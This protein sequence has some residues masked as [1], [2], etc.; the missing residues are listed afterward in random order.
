MT[1]D[2]RGLEAPHRRV[3]RLPRDPQADASVGMRLR[4]GL[5]RAP[6]RLVEK[7]ALRA[8]VATTWVVAHVPGPLSRWVI[9]TGSQAGYLFWPEKRRW[10]NANF[11]HVAGLPPDDLRVRRMALGAYREYARYLVEV[12]HLES[13]SAER[14]GQLVAQS[15]LD[16]VETIWRRS[17]GGLI[18]ALGH[19]GNNEAVA[20]AAA[21]RG[22]PVNVVADDSSFPEMFARFTALREAWGVH[23]IPW[24]NLREI[25]GVLKRREM[26]ALLVD[27][28]YRP[29]GIPVRLFDAWTTLPAGPASLAAKTGSLI[30]PLAIRRR[31][32]GE[33]AVAYSDPIEVASSAPAD[34]QAATQAIADALA[35]TIGAAPQQW[36]SFKPMW[37]DTPEEEAELAKRAATMRAGGRAAQA[38][39]AEALAPEVTIPVGPIDPAAALAVAVE[40]DGA[41]A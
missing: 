14:A 1:A 20:A 3:E 35:A 36:Y 19:V 7:I 11:G 6:G 37:P 33:F 27:W 32:N 18:F 10:S 24:R 22:W 26:L 5:R 8:Y 38:V 34:I 13:M 39:A 15:E 29:D 17:K 30:L 40:P 2:R 16:G 23:V 21:G 41:G 28:G 12:M 9:G 25:Y 4:L 31:P